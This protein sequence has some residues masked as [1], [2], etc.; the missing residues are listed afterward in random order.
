MGVE[1]PEQMAQVFAEPF[2]ARDTK[3]LLELY[4]EDAMFTFDGESRAVG[5]VQ[6]ERA[7]AGFLG[8]SLKFMGAYVNL[9]VHGDMALERMKYELIEEASGVSTPGW[10]A[11][12]MR[13]DVDGK[14]RFVIDD[15]CGSRR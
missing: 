12:V 11:E 10:S 2:N 15:A 8:S 6:I 7:L 5:L 9:H 3:G 13:R 4:A 14:W 1:S